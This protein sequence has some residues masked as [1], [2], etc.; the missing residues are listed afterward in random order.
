VAKEESIRLEGTVTEAL[1][2]GCFKVKL[3]NDHI[4]LA[5]SSG[6]IR[7]NMIRIIVSDKVT[8]EMS[9][10]DMSKGRITFRDI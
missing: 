9:P 4:V 2:N 1:P 6:K 8:V 10:Y 3:A 5:Y 7:T